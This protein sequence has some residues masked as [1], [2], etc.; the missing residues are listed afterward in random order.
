MAEAERIVCFLLFE[1][2]PK[3]VLIDLLSLHPK[4]SLKA[5]FFTA[6]VIGRN[7]TAVKSSIDTAEMISTMVGSI[8][9]ITEMVST[10][11]GGF[12]DTTEM[13]STMV[14][15]FSDITETISTIVGGFSDIT[16]TISTAVGG[17]TDTPE[18]FRR[19]SKDV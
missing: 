4:R 6:G 11:V 9:D 17:F 18:W 3:R 19:W 7:S 8:T 2:S 16:E 14:E 13:V 12:T 15:G 5:F 1:F 10:A